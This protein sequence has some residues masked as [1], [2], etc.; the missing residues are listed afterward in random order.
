MAARGG[1]AKSGEAEKSFASG[2]RS[3]RS[4]GPA[5]DAISAGARLAVAGQAGVPRCA[6]RMHWPGSLG[7]EIYAS[8]PWRRPD[9]VKAQVVAE[10]HRP[11]RL[12]RKWPRGSGSDRTS[13]RRDS[14]RRRPARWSRRWRSMIGRSRS[15]PRSWSAT[16]PRGAC[17]RCRL[18]IVGQLFDHLN[19]PRGRLETDRPHLSNRASHVDGLFSQSVFEHLQARRRLRREELELG[20]MLR[21]ALMRC[22]RCRTWH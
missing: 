16:A 21:S 4:P 8:G 6:R 13:F 9:E 12:S 5:F 20:R 18:A 7:V 1:T 22:P 15:S 17:L 10:P 2:M 19:E 3:K 14:S 11:A